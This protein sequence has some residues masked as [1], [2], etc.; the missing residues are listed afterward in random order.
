MEAGQSNKSTLGKKGVSRHDETREARMRALLGSLFIL[1][2]T[3]CNLAD[4]GLSKLQVVDDLKLGTSMEDAKQQ[5]FL[6]STKPLQVDQSV[7]SDSDIVYRGVS[8][9]PAVTA[10]YLFFNSK[11]QVLEQAEWRYHSGMTEA[12]E[13]ELLDFWTKKLW[14]PSYHRRWD[15]KVYVWSDRKAQLELYLADGICHLIQKL[16]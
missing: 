15:G 16:N 6:Y 3:G 9:D 5:W 12:K 14:V 2:L 10:F 4:R 8:R 7:G 13:E 11:T 1:F